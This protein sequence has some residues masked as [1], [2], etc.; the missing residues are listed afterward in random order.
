M[1]GPVGLWPHH[2]L[3][4]QLLCKVLIVGFSYLANYNH[5]ITKTVNRLMVDS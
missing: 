1:V 3:K 4:E 5:E 2:F